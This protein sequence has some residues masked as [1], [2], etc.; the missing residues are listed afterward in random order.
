MLKGK[1]L[2]PQILE[3]LASAGHLAKVLISDGNYPHS[4][5]ANPRARIVWANFTPGILD[6]VTA[7]R[8]VASAVPIEM[9][10]VMEPETSGAY[11]MNNDPPIWSDFSKVLRE[12]GAFDGELTP[13]SKP[14]F[15]AHTQSREVCLVIATAETQLYANVLITIGVVR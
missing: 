1:L 11:A 9:V 10:E 13:I 15:V 4:V 14:Q 5:G 12:T 6:V 8:L 2:H 7:L 3:S